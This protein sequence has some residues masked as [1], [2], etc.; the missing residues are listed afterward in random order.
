[1]STTLLKD[2]AVIFFLILALFTKLNLIGVIFG[3]LYRNAFIVYL[4]LLKKLRDYFIFN[5]TVV[6]IM[7]FY[8]VGFSFDSFNDHLNESMTFRDFDLIPNFTQF[9]S[10][11][12]GLLRMIVWPL[13]TISGLFFL[14][15]P[16][17]AYFPLFIGSVPFIFIY[18]KIG[19]KINDL[20]PFIF[21]L[22]FFAL[23]VPGYTT[24]FRYVFPIVCLLPYVFLHNKDR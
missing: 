8:A 2:S 3:G 14:I 15:S 19:I 11:I 21:L 13:I 7:Y 22:S 20:L 18:S 6:V 12:G 5:F 9:G 10:L 16:T 17:L 23:I 4:L 24:Y 1:L